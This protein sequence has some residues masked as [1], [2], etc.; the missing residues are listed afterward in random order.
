MNRRLTQRMLRRATVV[1]LALVSSGCVYF[2]GIYNANSAARNADAQLRRG[3][4][5]QA[6]SFFLTSAEKAETV[7]VRHPESKWR[8]QALYLAGRGEAYAGKCDAAADRLREYLS[9]DDADG[10]N[11]DRARLAMGVCDLRQ[12][13]V[14]SARTRFDSL[15]ELPHAETQRQARLWAARAALAAGDRDA[16]PRY[17]RNAADGTLAWE[18]IQSSLTAREYVR[19][20]SLLV[21]RAAQADYRD[22]TTRAL[23]EM[24]AAGNWT[25]VETIVRAYDRARVGDASRAAMHFQVGDLNMRQGRDTVAKEHFSMAKTLASQDT[26]IYREATAR[27]ALMSIAHV[28]SLGEIDSIYAREDSVIRATPYARR[29]REQVLLVRLLES[30][31]EP[32]GAS[33]FLAAE[34]ARDS[35][36]A[37][38]LA[39]NLFLRV[40]RDI[41]GAPMAPQ[42]LYAAGMLEPDSASAWTAT[43]QRE[44]GNSSVAAWLRGEDPAAHAD[45]VNTPPLLQVRWNQTLRVWSDSVR[46]L[47]TLPMQLGRPLNNPQP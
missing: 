23:R 8:T 30:V 17:L 19:V 46:K 22:A 32:T 13:R 35:L 43:I 12:A 14:A 16:V 45:F 40:A 47:R 29:L 15:I 33:V 4:D 24:W 25:G 37:P 3:S 44:F 9:R 10:D 21:Q 27:I 26:V 6:A 18:L 1:A 28:T 31:V 7:L 34:V 2:N 42:A 20:E 36:Q 11:R 41:P 5:E 39:R 38:V